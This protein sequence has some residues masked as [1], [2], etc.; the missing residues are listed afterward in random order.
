MTLGPGS[1]RGGTGASELSAA[2]ESHAVNRIGSGENSPDPECTGRAMEPAGS[3]VEKKTYDGKLGSGTAMVSG[4]HGNKWRKHW[5]RLLL[6][7]WPFVVYL[8]Y[9]SVVLMLSGVAS[10]L[11]SFTFTVVK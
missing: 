1:N 9:S 6:F 8:Q 2:K 7:I 3:G 10:I 5:R 11:A 4:S